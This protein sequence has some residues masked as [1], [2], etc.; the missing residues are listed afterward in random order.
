MLWNQCLDDQLSVKKLLILHEKLVRGELIYGLMKRRHMK[1]R[2]LSPKREDDRKGISRGRRDGEK[3]TNSGLLQVF[4]NRR[5][6]GGETSP[7]LVELELSRRV[8]YAFRFLR[9]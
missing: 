4:S 5:L 7:H 6:G 8:R 3:P 2:F 1:A 9:K